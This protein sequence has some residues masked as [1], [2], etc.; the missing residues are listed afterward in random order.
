[1]SDIPK[2]NA[3]RLLDQ[4]GIPY[5]VHTYS[6]EDGID[7]LSVARSLEEDPDYQTFFHE[8]PAWNPASENITGK[9][10][11]VR[12]ETISDPLMRKIRC[13]DKLVDELAAGRP[14]AKILNRS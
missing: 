5:K 2:T 3:M 10:C 6:A 13:L 8:A 11:G 9:I 12:I 7:G 14:V 1:M 4:A